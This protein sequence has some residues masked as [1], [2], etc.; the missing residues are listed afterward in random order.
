MGKKCPS[1]KI[2]KLPFNTTDPAGYLTCL[3]P[4]D[5]CWCET[6]QQDMRLCGT[7]SQYATDINW[8]ITRSVLHLWKGLQCQIWSQELYLYVTISKFLLPNE[9]DSAGWGVEPAVLE[10]RA[11]LEL[12]LQSGA[13]HRTTGS[14][15]DQ[16]EQEDDE[17]EEERVDM[18]V[19]ES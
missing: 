2:P 14:Q 7:S 17:R 11:I 8:Q 5:T 10:E 13:E 18:D 19:P 9:K 6:T 4:L 15:D 1:W 16:H 3:E 12:E